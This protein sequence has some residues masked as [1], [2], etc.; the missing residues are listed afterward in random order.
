[1]KSLRDIPAEYWAALEGKIRK[2]QVTKPHQLIGL[3]IAD[4]LNDR[5]HRALYIK[6]A[7]HY[8]TDWL[9]GLAKRVAERPDVRSR[10]AYFM[11]ILSMKEKPGSDTRRR[12]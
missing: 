8:D 10:G 7:Q 4:I 6:F 5:E 11:H 3:E 9:L 1:M 12:R 2:Q